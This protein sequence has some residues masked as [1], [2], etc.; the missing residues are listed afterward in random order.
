MVTLL[1]QPD[2]KFRSLLTL[3]QFCEF[4]ITARKKGG[5]GNGAGSNSWQ[6]A[7]I[8]LLGLMTRSI[9]IEYPG[10]FYNIMTRGNRREPIF[11]EKTDCRY[12]LKTL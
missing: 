11:L 8:G 6:V 4:K 5:K 2:K 12:F 3:L 1:G 9:R 10:R 7:E